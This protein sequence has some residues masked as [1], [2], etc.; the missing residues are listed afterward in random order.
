MTP[1]YDK[2]FQNSFTDLGT[3]GDL[4]NASKVLINLPFVFLEFAKLI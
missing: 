3:V 2:C 1:K 4:T